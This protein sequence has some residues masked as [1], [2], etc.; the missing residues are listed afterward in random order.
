MK[1][2][3]LIIGL[4]LTILMVGSFLPGFSGQGLAQDL[5][6]KWA[7]GTLKPGTSMYAMAGAFAKTISTHTP[8]FTVV[9]PFKSTASANLAMRDKKVDLTAYHNVGAWMMSKGMGVPGN[10]PQYFVRVA[11]AG[12]PLQFAPV[13]RMKSGLVSVK[14]VRGKRVA[15]PANPM[16]R[17]EAD[18]VIANA[19]LT[20][21][22]VKEVPCAGVGESIKLLVDGTVDVGIHALGSADVVRANSVISGGIRYLSLDPTPKA[23]AR[24]MKKV[25]PFTIGK[26]EKG[27]VPGIVDDTYVEEVTFYIATYPGAPDQAIYLSVKA[28][29][30]H[31]KEFGPV[32]R[33][34]KE[35]TPEKYVQ[36][37]GLAAPYH[38]GAIK[39]YKEVGLWNKDAQKAH[40]KILKQW[41]QEK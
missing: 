32:H 27:F 23:A 41:G 31:H 5:P 7:I 38:P 37:V 26:R 34:L 28:I 18:F 13:V 3:R 19:G 21:N 40:D 17:L 15:R 6:K 35:W 22:D 10:K 1:K 2:S 36:T 11:Q 33:L 14:E 12:A 30:E 25:A 39:F 9:V 8:L 4:S 16:Q 24:A 20:W 29:Y